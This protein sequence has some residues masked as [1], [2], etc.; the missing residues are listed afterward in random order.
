M[1]LTC[2]VQNPDEEY[3]AKTV[4]GYN[5]NKVV[6]GGNQGARGYGGV[7]AY[8]F[9]KQRDAGTYGTG[10]QHGKKKS[11][12]NTAGYSVCKQQCFSFK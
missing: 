1:L 9:E 2:Q 6:D 4:I 12:S 8:F 7:Y 11:D 5:G 3:P 10:N